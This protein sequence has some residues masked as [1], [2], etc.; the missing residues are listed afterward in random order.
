V[1]EE[2]CT[3]VPFAVADGNAEVV[4]PAQAAK[5]NA[6]VAATVAMTV[7]MTCLASGKFKR[8]FSR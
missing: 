5:A 3:H 8:R 1:S 7:L 2:V 6:D 4:G